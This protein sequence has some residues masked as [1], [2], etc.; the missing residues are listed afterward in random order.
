YVDNAAE[1]KSEALTRGCGQHGIELGYRPLGR[2]HYGGIVER[3]IGTAMGKV[4]ELPG[5]TFSNPAER[6]GYDSEK[7]AVLTLSELEK[8]LALAVAAYHGPVH[9]GLGQTPAGRW[10]EG[11]A[12]VG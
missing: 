3:L 8:W 10:A 2:P 5:T 9:G 6:G 7:M 12:A 11:V 1:F 4:H